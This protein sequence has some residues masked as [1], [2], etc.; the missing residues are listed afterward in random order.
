MQSIITRYHGPTA[1]GPSRI[2]ATSTAG[3][4]MY[5]SYGHER[6]DDQQHLD[7]AKAFVM[8]MDWHGTYY[9]GAY[10]D[11]GAQIWVCVAKDGRDTFTVAP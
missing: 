5:F 10:N 2:S 4:R 11:K 7:A 1:K 9:G 8:A 3:K 6:T